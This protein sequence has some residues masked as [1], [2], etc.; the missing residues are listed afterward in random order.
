MYNNKLPHELDEAEMDEW[1]NSI[2][3][4][5]EVAKKS[6]TIQFVVKVAEPI[7]PVITEEEEDTLGETE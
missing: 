3:K 6:K 4:A 7:D 5:R 1:L 2:K